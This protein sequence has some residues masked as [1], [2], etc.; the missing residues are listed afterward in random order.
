LLSTKQEAQVNYRQFA[1]K[2]Y[3]FFK[4]AIQPTSQVQLSHYGLRALW[5]LLAQH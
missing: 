2:R 3:Y 5:A 4:H 1:L